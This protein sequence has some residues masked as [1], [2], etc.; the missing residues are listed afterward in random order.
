MY[1]YTITITYGGTNAFVIFLWGKLTRGGG[2]M[3]ISFTSDPT[4]VQT[5]RIAGTNAGFAFS[6]ISR[7]PVSTPEIIP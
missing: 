7:V 3:V 6:G 4:T 1:Q 5:L 2:S